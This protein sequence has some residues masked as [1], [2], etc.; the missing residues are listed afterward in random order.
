MGG[1]VFWLGL[2]AG[3]AP[4]HSTATPTLSH[5]PTPF[6]AGTFVFYAPRRER[7]AW[8]ESLPRGPSGDG[9]APSSSDDESSDDGDGGPSDAPQELSG[10]VK[11]ALSLRLA[12]LLR[13]EENVLAALRRL[14]GLGLRAR[15]AAHAHTGRPP[16]L[17]R[18]RTVP[19]EHRAEF[20]ELTDVSA[21]L[22]AA[23]DVSAHVAPREAL[24]ARVGA[25][26]GGGAQ[27]SIGERE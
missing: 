15:R 25:A 13:P 8:L 4:R 9:G 14:G 2:Q 16:P 6:P 24:L 17:P 10:A 19:A 27:S 11:R 12:R 18:G 1:R 20:D 5:S 7:D 23:G 3:A 26:S 21:R 22:L